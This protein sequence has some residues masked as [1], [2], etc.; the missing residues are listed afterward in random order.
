M[1]KVNNDELKFSVKISEF[2]RLAREAR[3][4]TTTGLR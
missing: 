1:K 3:G 2:L 4:A